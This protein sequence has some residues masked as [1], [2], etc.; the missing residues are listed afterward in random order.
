MTSAGV[1][2]AGSSCES[3]LASPFADLQG[4]RET[5]D[6]IYAGRTTAPASAMPAPWRGKPEELK[7]A[8]EKL[9]AIEQKLLSFVAEKPRKKWTSSL[10][11]MVKRF[12]ARCWSGDFIT[13]SL[14][15]RKVPGLILFEKGLYRLSPEMFEL[16]GRKKLKR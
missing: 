3:L 15:S 4:V 8:R 2:K 10:T 11:C 5:L 7:K 9:G 13:R 16:S 12:Q 6:A 14:G 1:R